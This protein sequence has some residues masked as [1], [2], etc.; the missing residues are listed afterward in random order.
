MYPH[1]AIKITFYVNDTVPRG[2]NNAMFYVS[3]VLF[4]GQNNV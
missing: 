3:D 4:G 1:S 2:Q